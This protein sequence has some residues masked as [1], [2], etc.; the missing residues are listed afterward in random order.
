MRDG[1]RVY[2]ADMH[3]NPTA[4]ILQRYVDATF[5]T[6]GQTGELAGEDGRSSARILA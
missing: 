4:E 2:D 5:R 6:P 3:V 1:I